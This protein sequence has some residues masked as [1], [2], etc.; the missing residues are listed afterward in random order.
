MKHQRKPSGHFRFRPAVETLERRECF[1]AGISTLHTF[2]SSLIQEALAS[3]TSSSHI[4]KT[5][6]R[7]QA[8][9]DD[10]FENNDTMAQAAELGTISG[11]VSKNLVMADAADWFHF[12][13]GKTGGVNDALSLQFQHA[14]GDVD[15]ELRNANGVRLGLSE[16]TVNSERI[17]L[18]YRPAGDYYVKVYGYQGDTN[19][20]YKLTLQS[21]STTLTDDQFENND[22]RATASALG[23]LTQARTVTNLAMADSQDWFR[24]TMSGAGVASDYVS[25]QFTHSQGDLD[26]ALYNS[27]GQRIR[28]SEGVANSERVTLSGLAAGT[29]Y[30]NVYGYRGVNNANYSLTI[31]PGVQTVTPPPTNSGFQIDLTYSG[32]TASQQ[33]IFAQAANRWSQ[34]ITGDLPNATRNGVVIDDLLIRASAANIDGAGGVLGQAGPENFRNGSFIPYYGSMEFDTADLASMERDGSLY[35]V[36]L[37]EMGHVLGIGTIWDLTGLLQGAGTNTPIFVGARATAEYNTIFN[38]SARGVP[39]EQNGG[40]GTRDSHWDEELFGNELMSGYI[41]SATNPL[42]R[43]TVASLA[44]LGYTVNMAAADPYTP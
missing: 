6:V 23:S 7:A 12:R 11:T 27:N 5:S 8:L 3:I 43:I 13:L 42:S 1:T 40:A 20:S 33:T 22:T 28:L 29:Y 15:V 4:S 16:G 35:S 21:T 26:L 32:L 30:V 25:I 36:I 2:T 18:A 34:V 37:H 38:A 31:D 9:T 44:D 39:V 19:P 24:F 10:T 17:S 41:G 14:L